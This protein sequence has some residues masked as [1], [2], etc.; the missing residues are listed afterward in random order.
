MDNTQK[1]ANARAEY[2]RNEEQKRLAEEQRKV[3]DAARV[4]EARS[5]E[6][7]SAFSEVFELMGDTALI[8]D[9]L[10][11]GIQEKVDE[12]FDEFIAKVKE[13]NITTYEKIVP[14]VPLTA[15]DWDSLPSA[16]NLACRVGFDEKI[17]L[18]ISQLTT[19]AAAQLC[20]FNADGY[21]L[22]VE[23]LDQ[24][25]LRITISDDVDVEI[26]DEDEFADAII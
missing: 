5:A 18:F 10:K 17:M 19:L 2:A 23:L 7:S 15:L 1:I 6:L 11:V 14:F 25:N 22:D 12:V 3:A 8:I 16:L 21:K 9:K 13:E 26:D 4:R 20:K 24:I